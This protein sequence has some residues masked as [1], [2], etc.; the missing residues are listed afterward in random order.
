MAGQNQPGL[1]D[2]FREIK[3]VSGEILRI[4]QD[5]MEQANRK[6]RRMAQ[7]SLLWYG[8]GLAIGIALAVFLVASTIRTILHPIRAVTESAAAIGA[9]NLDQLVPDH[10]RG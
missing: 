7:S 8:A 9:G 10:F 6:A 2:T 3:A 5:N 4:N 1:Y